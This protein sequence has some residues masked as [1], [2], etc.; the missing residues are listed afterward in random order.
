[1][2]V[3]E[4][5][6]NSQKVTKIN[7]KFQQTFFAIFVLIVHVKIEN[8]RYLQVIKVQDKQKQNRIS[9]PPTLY[10]F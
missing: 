8:K 7:Y 3:I 1:M 2:C 4:N 6:F 5:Y 10:I 9:L